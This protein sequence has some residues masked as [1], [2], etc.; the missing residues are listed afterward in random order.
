MPAE[1]DDLQRLLSQVSLLAEQ[2]E[3][4]AKSAEPDDTAL[5]DDWALVMAHDADHAQAVDLVPDS[6]LDITTD[7]PLSSIEINTVSATEQDMALPDITVQDLSLAETDLS[8]DLATGIVTDTV[9]ASE[10]EI[11]TKTALATQAGADLPPDGWQQQEVLGDE[12]QALFF[13]VHGVTFAV[14]LTELGG[15][16]QLGEVSH[17]FGRPAWYLGLMTNRDHSLDVVD[18]AR[19]VMPE[20]LVDDAHRDAYRYLVMLGES[21]WGL[22]CDSL[23]GTQTL[24]EHS[25]RW[26]EQA[27][28]RPWLA[29]MVKKKCAH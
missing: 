7:A 11:E 25:V 22:A 1:R 28:K 10:T 24:H 8:T 21:R 26:R 9:L 13:E 18:T 4:E 16:H 6:A 5:S 29:G 3:V 17:L 12:F 20:R 14:P 19:W 2:T 23:Q 27:G 15:I